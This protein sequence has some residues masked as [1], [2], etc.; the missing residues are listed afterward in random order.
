M[1]YNSKLKENNI[2][3]HEGAKAYAITPELELYT[4]VVTTSLDD[5]FYE[6][7]GERVN[8]IVEL[9]G[10]VQPMFVA[11]LAVYTR[12][13]MNLR[14]VPLLLLVELA[15]RHNGDDLVSR[16]VEKTV[17]RADEIME[18]LMCYQWRNPN[19][20][21]VKK[22]GHLSRQIQVGLQKAFNKFDEYQFAKYDRDNLKVRLRDALF[23]VHP[24]AKNEDQ[25]A[26]FD[27]IANRQLE[28]P[29]TWETE[30]S[31]LG[32]SKFLT[33]DMR[34][35][36]FRQKWKELIHSCRLGYMAL[37]RNLRNILNAG[38]AYND[39]SVVTERISDAQQVA[40]SKQ[41]PFRFLSAYREIEGIQ[42]LYTKTVMDSLE[43]A[44]RHSSA[45]VEGF[46]E[47]TR[48]LIAAD[49]SGSMNNPISRNSTIKYYDIGLLLA[50][51]MQS[52]CKSVISGIFGDSWKPVNVPSNNILMAT[53]KLRQFMNEVGFS[54]NGHLAI[55]WLI[56]H[57][58][59]VDKV[60]M[61][62]DMQMWDSYYG[63]ASLEASWNRYK[64]IAPD[65]KLY[66][67]DL[68]GYGLAPLRIVKPDVYLIAGWS[69]RIFDILSAVDKGEDA[70]SV[71]K[72]I[73]I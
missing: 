23:V 13:V 58:T 19:P 4:A 14:S 59:V 70:L 57:N 37:L 68:V 49:V 52:R 65:A 73:K 11:Q 29:Y 40:K 47:N 17:N 27:K 5:S 41:L 54:T 51:L 16:A 44:V 12:T 7:G 72:Q 50:M 10:K 30:L 9:I 43:K 66:L 28:T 24:K 39:I 71:I 67:F 36:A 63:D 53:E 32:Q 60:M 21:S 20:D 61:F 18:L 69:D 8:R 56:E 45:N 1:K 33:D 35:D 42:S 46:D 62:T 48:V 6:R 31:A 26:I 38:V 2:T 64:Q 34:N 3:N 22:L 15:R 25:Q 55:D